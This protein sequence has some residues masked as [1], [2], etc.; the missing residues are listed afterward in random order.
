MSVTRN[1][2]S[3]FVITKLPG[4]A[5]HPKYLYLLQLFWNSLSLP[6]YMCC[7]AAELCVSRA[8]SVYGFCWPDVGQ[9]PSAKQDFKLLC[10]LLRR[11]WGRDPQSLPLSRMCIICRLFSESRW[12]TA[13]INSRKCF[14]GH[15]S[16]WGESSMVAASFI[17]IYFV[18]LFVVYS[19]KILCSNLSFSLS[20]SRLFFSVCVC[21]SRKAIHQQ[22]LFGTVLL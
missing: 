21:Q 5:H 6:V 15:I 19:E 13:V 1:P 3:Q 8:V 20:L 22:V 16:T 17:F 10:S 2:F 9:F 14:V 12:L 11:L 18:F 4:L 7:S